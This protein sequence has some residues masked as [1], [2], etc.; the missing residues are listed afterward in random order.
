MNWL[1]E[2]GRPN[3]LITLRTQAEWYW[4]R[5]GNQARDEEKRGGGGSVG[6]ERI[7]SVLK[8]E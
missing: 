7:L 2:R 6:K 4:S 1:W 3:R 8:I 5:D